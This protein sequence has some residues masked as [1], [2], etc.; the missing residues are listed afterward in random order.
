MPSPAGRGQDS[1]QPPCSLCVVI[2]A[3][4]L[5]FAAGKKNKS[6]KNLWLW[7]QNKAKFLCLVALRVSSD[8]FSV[9]WCHHRRCSCGKAQ[10]VQVQCSPSPPGLSSTWGQ[11]EHDVPKIT[12]W[13]IS[14]NCLG[15]LKLSMKSMGWQS[16]VGKDPWDPSVF[17]L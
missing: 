13:I 2:V 6:K 9:F 1:S 7:E 4:V 16:S 5:G 15:L 17:C 14:L 8:D 11:E 12:T 10:P 3:S